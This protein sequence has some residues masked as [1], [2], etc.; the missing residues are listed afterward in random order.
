[1]LQTWRRV[2]ATPTPTTRWPTQVRRRGE[3]ARRLRA[4]MG[5]VEMTRRSRFFRWKLEK[6]LPLLQKPNPCCRPSWP[7]LRSTLVTEAWRSPLSPFS[8]SS[9]DSPSIISTLRWRAHSINLR[10]YISSCWNLVTP[11]WICWEVSI[12]V[13]TVAVGFCVWLLTRL[14]SPLFQSSPTNIW[15]YV[16]IFDIIWQ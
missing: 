9:S 7:T 3:A 12:P 15:Q 4:N 5:T 13:Q 6:K 16:T 2:W 1:M 11:N 8:S 10:T 14:T